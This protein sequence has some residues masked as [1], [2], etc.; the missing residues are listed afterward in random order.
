MQFLQK[1][2]TASIAH[3]FRQAFGELQHRTDR[4]ETHYLCID[5]VPCGSA[6]APAAS[7]ASHVSVGR[8]L[9]AL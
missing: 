1:R 4:T 7:A 2:T 5:D 3:D 6:A 9:Q 8:S